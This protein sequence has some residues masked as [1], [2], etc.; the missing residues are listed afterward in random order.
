M[1]RQLQEVSSESIYDS[2]RRDCAVATLTENVSD[3]TAMRRQ[4]QEVSSESIYD[5]HRR[6]CAVA[7]LTENV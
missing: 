4:L 7:T 2:H 1:R 5:S 3:R 6:D